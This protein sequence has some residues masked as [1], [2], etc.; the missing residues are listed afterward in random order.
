MRS[1]QSPAASFGYGSLTLS[2]AMGTSQRKHGVHSVTVHLTFL[3]MFV[4]YCVL[5]CK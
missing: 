1:M 3:F 5:V 2:S 4:I